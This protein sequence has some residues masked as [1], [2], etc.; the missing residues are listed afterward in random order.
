MASAGTIEAGRAFVRINGDNSGLLKTLG[1]SAARLKSFAGVVAKSALGVSLGGLASSGVQ[2]VASLFAD[3]ADRGSDI[4]LLSKRF[5]VTTQE[6]SRLAYAFE[7]QGVDMGGF[8]GILDGLATS[9]SN[10][11]DGAD[12]S[13]RRIGLSGRYLIS[14][15]LPKALDEIVDGLNRITL[16]E[17]RV[18]FANEVGLGSLLPI[19]AKGSA[20]LRELGD[21]GE[22][23]GAVLTPE[24][25]ARGREVMLQYTHTWVNLRHAILEAGMSLLPTKERIEEI[26]QVVRGLINGLRGAFAELRER[27]AALFASLTEVGGSFHEVAA[28]VGETWRGIVKA[29]SSGDLEGAFKVLAAGTKA[30]WFEMLIAMGNAFK[31]WINAHRSELILIGTFLGA[32]KGLQ[33]GSQFGPW[34]ALIGTTAG[35]IAGGAAANELAKAIAGLGN[36]PALKD[37]AAR[38]RRELADAIRGAGGRGGPGGG[39]PGEEFHGT[40]GDFVSGAF[41]N[42]LHTSVSIPGDEGGIKKLGGVLG[43]AVKGAF[44]LPAAQQQFGY[45]DQAQRN[46]LDGIQ[47]IGKDAGVLP[48]IKKGIDDLNKNLKLR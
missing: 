32:M 22:R 31:D 20:G 17:D 25:A 28:T 21:E 45:G 7:R 29:V 2:R 41:R 9:L 5:G 40:L 37:S 24:Q 36:N 8:K 6:V 46:V 26:G 15:P 47:K 34:G 44:A 14:L 11:A 35:G 23:A 30:I 42:L 19:L 13:F 39:G 1:E 33:I 4:D 12:D 16:Q 18:K 38:A 3:V 10:A 48:D 43:N 27:T